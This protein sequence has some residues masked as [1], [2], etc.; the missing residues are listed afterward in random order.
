MLPPL[1]LGELQTPFN[2]GKLLNIGFVKAVE[3]GFNCFFFH[4]VDLIL[5]DDRNLY[6]CDES[7]R[8]YA[9]WIS[10]FDYK[11]IYSRMFGGINSFQFE[12]FTKVNGY[13]NAYWGRAQG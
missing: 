8:H 11:M 9:A 5:E 13:S 3:D 4:D 6:F 7:P 12:S 10:K 2:R 1:T